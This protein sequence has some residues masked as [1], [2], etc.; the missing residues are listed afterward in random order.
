MRFVPAAA[1][2][3]SLGAC[4]DQ[5]PETDLPSNVAAE[6]P[7]PSASNLAG[8]AGGGKTE[9]ARWDVQSSG[10]GTA[11]ALVP[12]DGKT[13]IRMFCEAARGS[14]LVNVPGFAP[15]GS[16]ERMSFGSGGEVVALVADPHGD[17]QRG[18]VSGSG[19]V[20]AR[21]GEIVGGGPAATY[22]AQ[23]SGPHP[24]PPSDMV[25]AFVAACKDS[26]AANDGSAPV[27]APVQSANPCMMQ[28]DERL[29]V[30]PV[31]AI[32]T[33]PFWGARIEGR[34]VTYSH[35]EDQAGTRVWSRYAKEG[36]TESWT[37]ALGGRPFVLRIRPER[38]CSD[39]MS[40]RRYPLAAELVVN[41][42]TR[43]GCARP[44]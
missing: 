16:E 28:G 9:S 8:S 10:E 14:I 36:A 43:S 44:A 39:G 27:P 26:A 21:L 13:V 24:P 11:L 4:S 5:G 29:A 15:I 19:P 23:K 2:L 3:L 22:G 7:P 31:R 1:I 40:D 34:C 32:G 18:G 41:G 17:V 12:A 33:E 30:R 37:G 25:R 42:E 38:N 20:P 35:P 6:A